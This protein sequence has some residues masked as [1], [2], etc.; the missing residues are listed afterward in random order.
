MLQQKLPHPSIN[1]NGRFPF[2]CITIQRSLLHNMY[3]MQYSIFPY[4]PPFFRVLLCTT[5]NRRR[6]R[7]PNAV[8]WWCCVRKCKTTDAAH[9]EGCKYVYAN[10]V[11]ICVCAL[12]NCGRDRFSHF[13][14]VSSLSV[15]LSLVFCFAAHICCKFM[16]GQQEHTHFFFSFVHYNGRRS[17]SRP[18]GIG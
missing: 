5:M 7:R 2:P 15:S 1:P 6:R 16:H 17:T 12:A 11:R 3:N 14:S 4:S 10:P 9:G 13:A 8:E 18:S